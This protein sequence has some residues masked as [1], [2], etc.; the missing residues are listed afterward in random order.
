MGLRGS[1]QAGVFGPVALQ[2]I[3]PHVEPVFF[4]VAKMMVVL[5][6]G[7][8]AAE[9]S[10]SSHGR[11]FSALDRGLYGVRGVLL[12]DVINRRA[13]H[14]SAAMSSAGWTSSASASRR[15]VPSR[16]G[17][18]RSIRA[19]VARPTPDCLARKSC[20]NAFRTRS[21][22]SRGSGYDGGAEGI[23]SIVNP[24]SPVCVSSLSG[25]AQFVPFRY[26]ITIKTGLQGMAQ[27]RCRGC[28]RFLAARQVAGWDRCRDWWWCRPCAEREDEKR[29]AESVA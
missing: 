21:T 22:P 8:V 7:T 23:R 10:Q 28:G 17:S 12:G 2:A 19:M 20:V 27:R 13:V 14:H 24:H 25:L 26:H 11:D 16:A 3:G 18:P 5:G 1:A 9:A 29:F 4:G 15:I 6:R